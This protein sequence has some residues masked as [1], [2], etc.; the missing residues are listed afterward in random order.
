MTFRPGGLVM[1]W[2]PYGQS[3]DEFL[4]H[5]RTFGSVFPEVTLA[6]GPGNHGI[7]LLGSADPARFD[8]A[9][10]REVLERPGVLADLAAASDAPVESIDDWIDLIPTLVIASGDDVSRVVGAGAVITDDRPLTE[11]FLLRQITNPGAVPMT[12]ESI[13]AAFAAP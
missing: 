5:V 13:A 11:Y 6:F 2:M 3:L 1:Q 4:T 7:F 10:I 9:A 8:A 12:P